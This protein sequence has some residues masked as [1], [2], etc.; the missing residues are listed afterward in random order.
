MHSVICETEIAD[1]FPGRLDR[2]SPQMASIVNSSYRNFHLRQGNRDS[3]PVNLIQKLSR[4]LVPNSHYRRLN[5]ER[6]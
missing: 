6:R 4:H 2:R 1:N 5:I 3:P